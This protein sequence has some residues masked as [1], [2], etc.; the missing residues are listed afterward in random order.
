MEADPS[1]FRIEALTDVRAGQYVVYNG[2]T[3]ERLLMSAPSEPWYYSGHE[4]E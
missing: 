4:T 2:E 3:D 1:R